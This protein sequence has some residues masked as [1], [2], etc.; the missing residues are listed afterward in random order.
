MPGDWLSGAGTT[1][2]SCPLETFRAQERAASPRKS[3]DT[4]KVARGAEQGPGIEEMGPKWNDGPSRLHYIA[5]YYDRRAVNECVRAKLGI[6]EGRGGF[7]D[8]YYNTS[9]L[10]AVNPEGARLH[11]RTGADQLT[12]NGVNLKPIEKAIANGETIL[13][14]QTDQ[15]VR[16]IPKAISEDK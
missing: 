15:T 5:D 16:A 1:M 12:V 3:T 9:I 7:G 8:N 2:L 4:L 13:Q 10:M 6:T 11:E 14:M